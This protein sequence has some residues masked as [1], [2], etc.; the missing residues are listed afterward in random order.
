MYPGWLLCPAMEP[1]ES[2]SG[3]NRLLLYGLP[4]LAVLALVVI[5]L[6]VLDTGP[7]ANDSLSESE[8]LAQGDQ[9]CLEAREEF[10]QR[11]QEL[12]QTA[13]EAA[14]LAESLLGISRQEL[15]AI[16]ELGAPD[17]LQSA[18]DEYLTA[19]EAGIALLRV[20]MEAARNDNVRGYTKAQIELASGQGERSELAEA[21]G[22]SECSRP[23]S[24]DSAG[25]SLDPPKFDPSEE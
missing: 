10:A 23:L 19:R 4:T 16:E 20:G 9:I 21:V 15:E 25:Q 13:K 5:I 6:L 7:F 3:A 14:D 2:D 8:F 12:P 17:Q 11:Q 1:T 22:F 18:L 24:A